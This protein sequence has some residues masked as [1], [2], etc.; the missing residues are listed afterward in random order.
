MEAINSAV[1]VAR[2]L[3]RLLALQPVYARNQDVAAYDLLLESD[4]SHSDLSA[5]SLAKL[6]EQLLECYTGVRRD[7]QNRT[8]PTLL[9][10]A[11]EVLMNPNLPELPKGHYIFEFPWQAQDRP[12]FTWH[13]QQLAQKGYRL[14]ISGFGPDSD[15]LAP[16]LNIV[17][18]ARI[19]VDNLG[20]E[21]ALKTGDRLRQYSLDLMASNLQGRDQFQACF[22][23]GF[24]LFRGDIF[25]KPTQVSGRRIASNKLV[26]LQLLAEL[27]KPTTTVGNLEAIAIKD[28]E[29]TYRILRVVSSASFGLGR[30]IETLSQAIAMLGTEQLRRWVALFLADSE[31]DK[32]LELTRVM[33]TR[34]RMC[35]IL[36]EILGRDMTLG[37]FM[38]GLLSRLDVLMDMSMEELMEQVPLNKEIRTALL[39][40][41]GSL[42]EILSEV[43]HY[44]TGHFDALKNLVPRQYYEVAYRHSNV[45]AEQTLRAMVKSR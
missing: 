3:D 38:V 24:H 28:P 17:H 39:Y 6:N 36:A 43:E 13:L 11:P 29:L 23:S 35:E 18:M 4:S 22:E 9:K 32:S 5:D 30:E 40:R 10:V 20:I 42:G 8:I 25:G 1:Q 44:E 37:H 12:G 45:W 7:A 19:D 26:L 41:K 31:M 2:P 21:A 34:G 33:L 27:Q 14:A 15:D 16:I